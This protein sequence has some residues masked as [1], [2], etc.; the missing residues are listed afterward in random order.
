MTS[1]ETSCIHYNLL[2]HSYQAS[3][4]LQI[5]FEINKQFLKE[6]IKFENNTQ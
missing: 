3:I 1:M 4:K 5:L 2:L 6:Y